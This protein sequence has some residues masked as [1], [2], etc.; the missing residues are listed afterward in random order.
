MRGWLD[1][2]PAAPPTSRAALGE[3]VA[4]I[5]GKMVGIWYSSALAASA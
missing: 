5:T 4:A 1:A 3:V 2:Q